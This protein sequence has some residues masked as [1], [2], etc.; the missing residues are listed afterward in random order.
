MTNSEPEQSYYARQMQAT[1]AGASPLDMTGVLTGQV[2][3]SGPFGARLPKQELDGEV[4]PD[5][6]EPDEPA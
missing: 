6:D 5:E 2:P 3:V 1:E 4:L